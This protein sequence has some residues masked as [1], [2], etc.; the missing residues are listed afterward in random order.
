MS[1]LNLKHPEYDELAII[2]LGGSSQG[3]SVVVHIGEGHWII[4]DS[5]IADKRPLPLIY[6]NDIGADISNVEYVICTHWH[7]DHVKGLFETL[8]SCVNAKFY[9]PSITKSE[10]YPKFYVQTAPEYEISQD[11]VLKVMQEFNNCMKYATDS[12]IIDFLERD[13]TLIKRD[14]CG[15][16]LEICS[17]SPSKDM[18]NRFHK[19]FASGNIGKYKEFGIEPNM[20]SSAILISVNEELHL[21]LGADLET[22]RPE[23]DK[24]YE[25]CDKHCKNRKQNGWC[26]VFFESENHNYIDKY[27]YI[28]IP[29]HS[30]RTGFC[31]KL[32]NE[33]AKKEVVGVSTIFNANHIPSKDMLEIYSSSCAEYYIS[34]EPLRYGAGNIGIAEFD[35]LKREGLIKSAYI[36]NRSFGAICTKYSICSKQYLGTEIDGSAIKFK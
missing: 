17:I 14:V 5:Y 22:C 19:M 29:H 1:T 24:D 33:K 34:A 8:S 31:P 3:E 15:Q 9:A 35:T 7:S 4:I 10:Y 2:V 12:E 13:K 36:S 27:S 18:K 16:K 28:K 26:N 21:L 30:S 32:W 6:L 11:G 25:N 20:C 23:E